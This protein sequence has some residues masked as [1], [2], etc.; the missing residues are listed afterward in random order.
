MGIAQ[1]QPSQLCTSGFLKSLSIYS[2]RTVQ[3][4]H[5][6]PFSSLQV[7]EN[8]YTYYLLLSI[9]VN[10]LATRNSKRAC[11]TILVE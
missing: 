4:L 8:Q 1:L 6:I 2:G 10:N 11:L 9:I 7:A 3:D 5:L